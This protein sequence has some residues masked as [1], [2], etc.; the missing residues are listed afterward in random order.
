MNLECLGEISQC[1][2]ASAAA[3]KSLTVTLD[4]E[5]VGKAQK[6][7]SAPLSHD[8]DDLSN[9]ELEDELLLESTSPVGPAS[10]PANEADIRQEKSAQEGILARLFDLESLAPKGKKL[11]RKL[12]LTGGKCLKEERHA[13]LD[14]ELKVLLKSMTNDNG[15]SS[16]NYDPAKLE[17]L[18]NLR[19]L[20][21]LYISEH[22]VQPRN[23]SS[24]EKSRPSPAKKSHK[25]P[26]PKGPKFPPHIPASSNFDPKWDEFFD[27]NYKAAMS[28]PMS[29]EF[30]AGGLSSKPAGFL[31][32]N[33]SSLPHLAPPAQQIGG[34]SSSFDLP[35]LPYS[36]VTSSSVDIQPPLPYYGSTK[37]SKA[38]MQPSYFGS[39]LPPY[40]SP[41]TPSSYK[42]S[43]VKHPAKSLSS[44]GTQT[45]SII[46]K[47]DAFIGS[48]TYEDSPLSPSI[49]STNKHSSKGKGLQWQKK[50]GKS[51]VTISS[52]TSG[53]ES[54]TPP[55][56]EP[57][58]KAP[59][60]AAEATTAMTDNIDV[61]ID[62]PDEDQLEFGDDQQSASASDGMEVQTPR[63]RLK[64]LEDSRVLPVMADGGSSSSSPFRD[65][66]LPKATHTDEMHE[67]IRAT[68]GLQLEDLRLHYV[69]MKASI[70]GKALDLT[71]L[72]HVTL[73]ETGPQDA[74]WTLLVK[75]GNSGTP[76]SFKSIHTDNVTFAFL[77]YVASFEGLEELFMHERKLKN[78]DTDPEAGVN[79]DSIREEVLRRH[80]R[81]LKRLMLRNER[82]AAWDVDLKTL[83]ML[84]IHA[85][86]L[87]ELAVNMKSSTYVCLF[88]PFS[89]VVEC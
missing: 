52:P 73:L 4:T 53:D 81:T 61:D 39:D 88:A 79:I 50:T 34:A 7:A 46:D 23:I 41:Y 28:S 32:Y 3:L 18:Q 26:K 38:N 67:Y 11:E 36:E 71:V 55:K 27:E 37:K 76:I 21:D 75:L 57:I 25:P 68:H 70:I 1:I 58:S 20:A 44:S 80:G 82:N 65:Q 19:R 77:K 63:K 62:H 12:G 2:K 8:L 87:E 83:H 85:H 17:K 56:T 66:R 60:F 15:L 72:R 22:S 89:K 48:H 78:N 29:A 10:Q 9:T 49:M 84:A 14:S 31:P 69:P 24:P 40:F 64:P 42:K 74:F 45:P 6:S 13:A 33:S 16:S 59:F 51:S 30:G 54:D 43:L 47:Y 5:L 86:A 35:A